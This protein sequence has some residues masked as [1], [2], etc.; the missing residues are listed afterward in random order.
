M[1]ATISAFEDLGAAYHYLFPSGTD[2]WQIKHKTEGA[3][4]HLV[5][6]G[7]FQPQRRFR[8]FLPRRRPSMPVG[9]RTCI[10]SFF[11]FL[12]ILF[13]SDLRHFGGTT[14]LI[15]TVSWE[16]K[17]SW[18]LGSRL[19]CSLHTPIRPLRN[20]PGCFFDVFCCCLSSVSKLFF[21]GIHTTLTSH[22]LAR[23]SQHT[24]VSTSTESEF[25]LLGAIPLFVPLFVDF[26]LRLDS[27]REQGFRSEER[28]QLVQHYHYPQ[29]R[30]PTF[31]HASVAS[32]IIPSLYFL[33]S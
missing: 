15:S 28:T 11:F 1:T 26:D 22:H 24:L 6:G 16:A 19:S 25:A 21:G 5:F 20:G 10:Y 27:F 8:H 3:Q 31:P 4:E 18:D 12:P 7:V 29:H 23:P 17:E 14:L 30:I 2:W 33:C 13:P 9:E 32:P